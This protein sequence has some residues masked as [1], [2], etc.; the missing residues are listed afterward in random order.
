M[1]LRSCP[2]KLSTA[3]ATYDSCRFTGAVV[4]AADNITIRRSHVEGGH[5]EGASDADLR[6][7]QLVDVEISGPVGGSDSYAAVGNSRYSCV[8]CDIHG[9]LRGLALGSNVTIVDSYVHDLRVQPG[10]HQ[11][12]AST[13]GGAHVRIEHSTL[14]C[15]SD[16]F[17]CSNGVSFYSE[18]AP[19]IDDVLI[20]RSHLSTDAGF[21]VGFYSLQAG[22]PYGITNV[23]MVDNVLGASEFGPVANWPA[24]QKGNTWSGNTTPGGGPI[25]P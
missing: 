9:G 7:L 16:R 21:C 14:R 5:V 13:H 3:G 25:K 24:A 2:T 15:N 11:T 8:R 10:S 6:G 18:D 4:I 19:G 17:A 23:R 1:T 22:K 20:T 12:A